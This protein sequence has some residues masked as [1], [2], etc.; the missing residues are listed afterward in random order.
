MSHQDD[1]S[2]HGT[3]LPILVEKACDSAAAAASSQTTQ[4]QIKTFHVLSNGSDQSKSRMALAITRGIMP[5]YRRRLESH[6][7]V[8]AI[9]GSIRLGQTIQTAHPNGSYHKPRGG[10]EKE[11]GK[12]PHGESHL[13]WYCILDFHS[14]MNQSINPILVWQPHWSLPCPRSQRI[15]KLDDAIRRGR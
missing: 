13:N 14:G 8:E 3:I 15:K 7:S 10:S 6:G 9:F 4:L 2:T 11:A 12:H 5:G 1:T